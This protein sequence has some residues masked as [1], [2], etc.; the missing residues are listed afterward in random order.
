VRANCPDLESRHERPGK[1]GTGRSHRSQV[2]TPV[3]EG[4][5]QKHNSK[6]RIGLNQRCTGETGAVGL[7][8]PKDGKKGADVDTGSELGA[9]KVCRV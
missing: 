9:R 7:Q 5:R 4:I 8:D 2:K 3:T 6:I 1:T